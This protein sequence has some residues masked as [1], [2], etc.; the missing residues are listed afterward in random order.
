[1]AGSKG[2]RINQAEINLAVKNDIPNVTDTYATALRKL[3]IVSNMLDN[4]ENPILSKNWGGS[5]KAP[6]S[7]KATDADRAYIKSLGIK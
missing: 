3:S 1:M 6:S 5:S 2:L 4:A 7:P